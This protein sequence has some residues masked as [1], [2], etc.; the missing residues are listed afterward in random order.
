[1]KNCSKCR[2]EKDLGEFAVYNGKPWSWCKPC[3]RVSSKNYRKAHPESDRETARRYR[4]KNP[5][6]AAANSKSWRSENP[7][8]Y[9]AQSR[10]SWEKNKVKKL[11]ADRVRYMREKYGITIEQYDSMYRAQNGACAVCD[12]VNLSGRRLAVDHCH[13]TG[14]VRGLLCSM[15]NSAIGLAKERLDVLKKAVAY[16]EKH[17]T[18]ESIGAL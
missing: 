18:L 1:M 6:Y 4:E 17:E 12:G 8:K 7:E 16:L 13:R 15:C 2:T 5:S 9:R 11:A 14:K 3:Q 10:R